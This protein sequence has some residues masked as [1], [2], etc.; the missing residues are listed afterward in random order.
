LFFAHE[1]KANLDWRYAV[2]L[3][4]LVSVCLILTIGLIPVLF[5][6]HIIF[7]SHAHR[8]CVEHGQIE[9]VEIKAQGRPSTLESL[10]YSS[11]KGYSCVKDASRSATKSHLA[12]TILNN[13]LSR[14][15]LFPGSCRYAIA[16]SDSAKYIGNIPDNIE[17]SCPLV[18]LAPK[19][20]P[21]LPA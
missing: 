2:S 10:E 1:K 20:S 9:D 11:S 13:H 8:Y 16:G 7:A 18:L 14:N 5:A 15:Q 17:P 12:C 21:P 4:A 3:K 6:L 19:Q